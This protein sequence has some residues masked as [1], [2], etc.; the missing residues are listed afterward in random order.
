MEQMMFFK[1]S[2]DVYKRQVFKYGSQFPKGLDTSNAVKM[3][4]M[5][6]SAEL[7]GKVKLPEDFSTVNVASM[8]YMF[9]RAFLNDEL[10]F[11]KGFKMCIRDR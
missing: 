6:Y 2:T 8:E 3:D 7:R 1:D 9:A 11:P 10:I 4:G 5:F